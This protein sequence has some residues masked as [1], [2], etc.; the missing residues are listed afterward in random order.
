MAFFRPKQPYRVKISIRNQNESFS[1]LNFEIKKNLKKSIFDLS[2]APWHFQ[3][4]NCH[5]FTPILTLNFSPKS[6]LGPYMLKIAEKSQN[7]SFSKSSLK[8]RALSIFAIFYLSGVQYHFP[9]R[10]LTFSSLWC[11]KSANTLQNGHKL[12]LTG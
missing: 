1:K 2:R 9:T 7:E 11:K 8:I 6:S 12:T 5:Q 3:T 4:K 10:N